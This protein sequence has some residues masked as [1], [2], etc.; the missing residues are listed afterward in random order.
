MRRALRVHRPAAT[1]FSPVLSLASPLVW[2]LGALVG[3]GVA[4]WT[5][6]RTPGLA[7]RRRALLALLRGLALGGIAFVL[8]EP[9]VRRTTPQET[10]ATVAVL[11][12]D[13]RSVGVL[14]S[15]AGGTFRRRLD[16]FAASVNGPARLDRALFHRTFSPAADFSAL[17][18]RGTKTDLAGALVRA[19]DRNAGRN[20]QAVV[21]FTDGR[22]TTGRDPL[23]A[24]QALGVPVFPVMLGDTTR[25]ER[26]RRR[27]V[28]VDALLANPSVPGGSSQPVE[29][30]VTSEGYAGQTA[31]VSLSVNGT[32]VAAKP[33]VLPPDGGVASVTLDYTPPAAGVVA[34][35]ASAERLAGEATYANNTLGR[36]VDVRSERLKVLLLAGAPDPDVAVV[37]AALDADA[38]FELTT[39]VQKAAGQFFDGG[40]VEPGPFDVAVLVGFPGPA[41]DPA[42]VQRLADAP[43]VGLVVVPTTRLDAARA[44]P[45]APLLAAVPGRLGAPQPL[46]LAPAGSAHPALEGVPHLDA[47]AAL[48]PLPVAPAPVAEGGRV[49]WRTASGAPALVVERRGRRGTAVLLAGGL[50]AWQSLPPALAGRETLVPALLPRLVRFAAPTDAGAG[51]TANVSGEVFGPGETPAFSAVATDELGKPVATDVQI[52]LT[53][54]GGSRRVPMQAMGEGRY[55]LTVPDLAPGAY[56]WRAVGA[57]VASRAGGAFRVEASEERVVAEELR[58]LGPDAGLLRALAQATGGEVYTLATLDRLAA[59]LDTS[60]QFR[61]ALLPRDAAVPVWDRWPIL[62][63]LVLL[64]AAEWAL[65]KRWG[66]V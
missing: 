51:L 17:R 61:P 7:R 19:A 36:T 15:L 63:A 27:D 46:A 43:R 9:L 16:G 54:P 32:V 28:A 10:P 56:R 22:A 53:G 47:L 3:A 30:R 8:A 42:L 49:L 12:D 57:G 25:A 31:R 38:G 5:Y 40:A 65:R 34:L 20:L 33:V 11:A 37:R 2:I 21:V 50:W 4:A 62:A 18:F 64:L 66:L 39:R 29:V 44:A 1:A 55:G 14:D 45:L 58:Q 23:V 13:S 52:E 26:A 6:A 48:P 24:A 41:S 35:A 60:P 59:R